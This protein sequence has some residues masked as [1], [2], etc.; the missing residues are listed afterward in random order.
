MVSAFDSISSECSCSTSSSTVTKDEECLLRRGTKM[1]LNSSFVT[2]KIFPGH[3]KQRIETKEVPFSSSVLGLNKKLTRR[4]RRLKKWPYKTEI[5]PS[6]GGSCIFMITS[7]DQIRIIYYLY[8]T[9]TSYSVV[10]LSFS[11]RP[12]LRKVRAFNFDFKH[13]LLYARRLR[14]VYKFNGRACPLSFFSSGQFCFLGRE[15]WKR[16]MNG[17]KRIPLLLNSYTD[18]SCPRAEFKIFAGPFFERLNVRRRICLCYEFIS[19]HHDHQH[20]PILLSFLWI[21]S[22][23]YPVP[24]L[25]ERTKRV[26]EFYPQ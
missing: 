20:F 25:C 22:T 12:L 26:I 19:S 7:S 10:H 14:S 18:P 17:R 8:S 5:L 23:Q 6:Y 3:S 16:I 4:I 11:L 1:L 15:D 9:P 21:F 13:F 2:L 24:S